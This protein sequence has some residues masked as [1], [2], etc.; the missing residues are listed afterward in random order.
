MEDPRLSARGASSTIR[1][2]LMSERAMERPT[3]SASSQDVLVASLQSM[4][5]SALAS[6]SATQNFGRTQQVT[7]G[8]SEAIPNATLS[9]YAI[10]A[11]SA[12]SSNALVPSSASAAPPLL[13]SEDYMRIFSAHEEWF[14]AATL[15]RQE[16]SSRGGR[17]DCNHR[18]LWSVG[19]SESTAQLL[20]PLPH[21]RLTVACKV[22]PLISC[23]P[24]LRPRAA[25]QACCHVSR[26]LRRSSL[27]SARAG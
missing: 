24:L 12:S 1:A 21:L 5:T 10:V 6:P 22:M 20:P 17:V 13:T 26:S 25:P 18:Q 16:V 3:A 23:A 14:R 7:S 15:K 8:A 9:S 2:P 11:A 19:S 4:A 27:M